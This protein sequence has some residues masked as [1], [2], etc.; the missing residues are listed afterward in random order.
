MPKGM[1]DTI[2]T[3]NDSHDNPNANLNDN[4]NFFLTLTTTTY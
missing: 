3:I 1:A 2:C 4:P